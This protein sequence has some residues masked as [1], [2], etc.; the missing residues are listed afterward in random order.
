MNRFKSEDGFSLIEL[1]VSIAI[2]ATSL[3]IISSFFINSFDRDAHT[4]RYQALDLCRSTLEEYKAK[5]IEETIKVEDYGEISGYDYN[6]ESFKRK[7]EIGGKGIKRIKVTVFWQQG[8]KEKKLSLTTLQSTEPFSKLRQNTNSDQ[9]LTELLTAKEELDRYKKKTEQ[10]PAWDRRS[11]DLRKVS[12]Y[13]STFKTTVI[14][15]E[16][17]AYRNPSFYDWWSE[18]YLI[19]YKEAV[20]GKFYCLTDKS[21]IFTVAAD[22]RNA[23]QILGDLEA[24][25]R[26]DRILFI[27]HA[28]KFQQE[29]D[30]NE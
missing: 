16:K 5:S 8:Q 27:S 14:N 30:R 9:I 17:I 29:S 7:I 20:D 24:D 1:S 11:G 2:F 21:G 26:R 18:G 23:K 28:N 22:G 6:T 4:L 3:I 15:P 12:D 25:S 19:L 13:Y 10:F